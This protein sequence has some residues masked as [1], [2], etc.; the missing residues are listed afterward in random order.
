MGFSVNIILHITSDNALHDITPAVHPRAR[1]QLRRASGIFLF[2]NHRCL[3]QNVVFWFWNASGL[4][5]GHL[6]KIDDFL[7]FSP[8][9]DILCDSSWPVRVFPWSD[10]AHIKQAPSSNIVLM[11]CLRLSWSV[12]YF[13]H[14]SWVK[15]SKN[16]T[17]ARTPR[18]SWRPV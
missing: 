9:F 3:C 17:S 7:E 14:K 2:R 4:I 13:C 15:G 6:Q 1:L 16:C 11:L 18:I 5:W 8:N 12:E 10:W